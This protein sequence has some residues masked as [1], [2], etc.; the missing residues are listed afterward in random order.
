MDVLIFVFLLAI[1][2]AS[3]EGNGPVTID[4][5]S[6]PDD[7]DANS[8]GIITSAQQHPNATHGVI[9][10]SLKFTK[11]SIGYS[12]LGD[13]EQLVVGINVSDFPPSSALADLTSDGSNTL[14]AH[15]VTTSYNFSWSSPENC[16]SELNSS[17]ASFCL[18][19]ATSLIDL[20]ANA[21]NTSTE[22]DTNSASCVSALGQAGVDAIL[23]IEKF[24][25]DPVY[26]NCRSPSKLWSELP[27]CQNTLG[28]TYNVSHSL[29]LLTGSREF[30]NRTSQNATADFKNGAGWFGYISSAVNSSGSNE[31]Y[32]AMNR[33]HIA[34][35]N[36]L[37][38]YDGDFDG[39]F[40]QDAQL[41]CMRVN[42][43]TLPTK[44]T[45]GDDAGFFV[46][47]SLYD[48]L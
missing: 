11:T 17:I 23:A 22:Q 48:I 4:G 16:T 25:D 20:P 35:V 32:T 24:E 10:R 21:T 7:L 3:P 5:A 28:Y 26:G 2:I 19:V 36:P 13:L 15:I 38:A 18:T 41:L 40:L 33:L 43:T 27:E 14:D 31:Y 1:V 9:F 47:V 29:D 30:S 42:A 8:L 37:L 6:I 44:D 46:A 12:T 39:G 34:M 45:N